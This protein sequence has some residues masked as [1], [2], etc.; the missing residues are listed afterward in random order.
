MA[1]WGYSDRERLY[2][3]AA[4]DDAGDTAYNA[5]QAAHGMFLAE[6]VLERLRAE[7]AGAGS[8]YTDGVDVAIQRVRELERRTNHRVITM[9]E[10]ESDEEYQ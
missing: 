7:L 4:A 6:S 1:S 10:D 3:Y 9:G 2:L 8:Y 5:R